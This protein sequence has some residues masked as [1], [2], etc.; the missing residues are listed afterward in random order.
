MKRSA[1][2]FACGVVIA[3]LRGLI[4]LGGAEFRL[5]A[6]TGWFKFSV[7]LAVPLN[8]FV[9]LITVIAS[10]VARGVL[11]GFAPVAQFVPEIASLAIG[12]IAGAWFATGLFAKVNDRALELAVTLLLLGISAILLAEAI[13]P[14]A[15]RLA[16]VQAPM[17]SIIVGFIVGIGIGM[18]S[19]LLGV[20]AG[21]LIIPVM[22]LLFGAD[23]KTAGTA[24]LAI[25]L[26]MVSVGVAR[27]ALAGTLADRGAI[28][29]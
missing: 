28:C 3:T 9:S 20:A 19:S 27:Y 5:P 24:S 2:A 21:E 25:S 12:G 10:F 7:R 13:L 17:L 1:G 16:F 26:P 15:E 23:I 29:V 4:G 22:L 14:F 18:V 11:I 8:L 6:L